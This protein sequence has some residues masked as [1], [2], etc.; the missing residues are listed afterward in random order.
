MLTRVQATSKVT[1]ALITRAYLEMDLHLGRVSRALRGFLEEE[2]SPSNFGLSIGAQAHLDRFR[3][4]LHS[5]YVN[6]FG[7]WPPERSAVLSSSLLRSLYFEFQNLYEFIVDMDSSDVLHDKPASGGICVLQNV[8]AFNGRHNYEPLPHPL[9]LLPDYDSSRGKTH[10]QRSLRSFKLGSKNAKFEQGMTIK[11]ALAMATNTVSAEVLECPLVRDYVSFE[12]EWSP[13]PQEK[14]SI[15]DAR[16]VRWIA[17]YCI[18]QMLISVTRAP[19]EVR[20][21]ED[22]SY[23]LCLLTTGTPPWDRSR[24]Y[25]KSGGIIDA[26]AMCSVSDMGSPSDEAAKAYSGQSSPALSIH[27][28]CEADDYFL[29]GSVRKRS[30]PTSP[31]RPAPLRVRTAPVTRTSSIRSIQRSVMSMSFS[32]RRSS[33]KGSPI[34]R[35]PAS[36]SDTKNEFGEP[37]TSRNKAMSALPEARTPV[38]DVFMLEHTLEPTLPEEAHASSSPSSVSSPKSTSSS[39]SDRDDTDA[40]SW[41]SNDER[42]N[43][44]VYNMDHESVY[45]ETSSAPSSPGLTF[46]TWASAS[47]F[48]HRRN[49]ILS[50]SV[51]TEKRSQANDTAELQRRSQQIIAPDTHDAQQMNLPTWWSGDSSPRPGSSASNRHG[52]WPFAVSV[53][54]EVPE[55]EEM[56]FQGREHSRCSKADDNVAG[57]DFVDIYGALDLLPASITVGSN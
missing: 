46:G 8:N 51:H 30:D 48:T 24:D 5:F 40:C 50:S 45:D 49:S 54:Q 3:S 14:I 39:L 23:P 28:D 41:S 44:K 34:S 2:L 26:S 43:S 36:V 55:D 47:K 33:V 37:C 27:P 25:S 15:V 21:T 10:S 7:Y 32:P 52:P 13:N 19:K 9:P 4:F 11:T 20:I 31:L 16:K 57:V 12:R 17:I 22:T 6:K 53:P 18:L 35:R 1:R 38:L 56:I 42:R 29:H